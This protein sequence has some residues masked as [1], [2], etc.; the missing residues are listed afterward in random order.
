LLLKKKEALKKQVGF[1]EV[2]ASGWLAEYLQRNGFKVERNFCDLPTAF[3]ASYGEGKPAVA[4]LAEYDALPELGHACGH[5]IIA[6]AS[7]GAGIA[8][9]AAVEQLVGSVLVIGTPGEEL[10]G[11]KI[12]MAGRGAFTEIDAAM[13]VHPGTQDIAITQALACAGLEVEFFGKAAHAAVYPDEGINALEALILAFNNINSLRQHIREGSRV[14]GIITNGGEAAN[15]V[16]AY[17]KASFLVRTR[18]EGYLVELKERVL[19]CFAAAAQATGA[20]LVHRWGE[21]DYAPMRNNLS[22]AHLFIRNMESLGR[23]VHLGPKQRSGSTDMGNVSQI[24]PAIHPNVAI[25][26]QGMSEHTPEFAAAAASETGHQAVLD[27][28]KALALTVV[29]LLSDPE[30]MSRVREEFLQTGSA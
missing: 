22:L 3:K 26:P 4:L 8:V 28:A 13:M 27:G 11:G 12:V 19:S 10:Y 2:K 29:D 21:I 14:H 18:E 23:R 7:V 5:N 9:K 24:V 30:T 25:A 20:R 15:I 16:P 6:T 1:R 17:T